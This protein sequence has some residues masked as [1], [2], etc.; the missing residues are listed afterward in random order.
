MDCRY[1]DLDHEHRVTE[2][3]VPR[4]DSL[5][6]YSFHLPEFQQ[7]NIIFCVGSSRATSPPPQIGVLNEGK[8]EALGETGSV[9]R[10]PISD[11]LELGI[12]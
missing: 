11:Y 3:Q 12:D 8:Y 9:W 4:K 2:Y 5:E 1:T 6:M 10:G 7:S